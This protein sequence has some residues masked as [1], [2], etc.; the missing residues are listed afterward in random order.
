LIGAGTPR[1]AA[2]PWHALSVQLLRNALG[3]ILG[4]GNG[5]L[6]QIRPARDGIARRPAPSRFA[7]V[8]A[9]IVAMS[10]RSGPRSLNSLDS[11]L[12][13]ARSRLARLS[14]SAALDAFRHGARLVD[15]RPEFQRRRDGE[16]PGAIVIERNHLEWRLVPSSGA[17]I[18]EAVADDVAWIILCDEGFASSLAAA[19]LQELGLPRATDV[20]GGF[21]A[22][23][24]AGL[25]VGR[26]G[27]VTSARLAGN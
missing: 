26:P 18:P 8:S 4:V 21:R 23:R 14:P 3:D 1:L 11:H 2:W 9:T 27:E 22:W 12:A 16:I 20:V 7:G 13:A 15:I 6:H 19:T 17:C 5:L 25:P 24:A 10:T